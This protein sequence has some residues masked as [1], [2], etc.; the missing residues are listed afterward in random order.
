MYNIHTFGL[1][2]LVLAL[3]IALNQSKTLYFGFNLC[4]GPTQTLSK[5]LINSNHCTYIATV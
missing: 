2:T 1:F 5:A 3:I 4:I